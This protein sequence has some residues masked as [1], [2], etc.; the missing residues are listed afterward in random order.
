MTELVNKDV[1]KT[2]VIT[3]FY[4]HHN[5]EEN[6]NKTQ[7]ELLEM[8]KKKSLKWKT[9]W[10]IKQGQTLQQKRL[11]NM[12]TAIETNQNENKKG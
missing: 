7:I 2:A 3:I 6:I 12:K 9:H 1:N 11:M 8:K 10:K 5:M 4:M